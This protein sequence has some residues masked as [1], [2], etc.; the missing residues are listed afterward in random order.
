MTAPLTRPCLACRLAIPVGDRE[1]WQVRV[2]CPRCGAVHLLD[3]AGPDIFK[4]RLGPDRGG[5]T[6][7]GNVESAIR[8]AGEEG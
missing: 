5:L 8:R 1:G 7:P 6:R 2:P 4:W 3:K